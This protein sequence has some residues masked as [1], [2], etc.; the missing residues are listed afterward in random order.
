MAQNVHNTFVQ[1]AHSGTMRSYNCCVAQDRS[2]RLK[3]ASDVYDRAKL[4]GI[5]VLTTEGCLKPANTVDVA[6]CNLQHCTKPC[7]CA[8]SPNFTVLVLCRM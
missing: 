1:T 3:F 2:T 7:S 6:N 5:A 8:V 4:I